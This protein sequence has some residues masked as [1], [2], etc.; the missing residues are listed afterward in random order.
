VD[1]EHTTL[2]PADRAALRLAAGTSP[3]A[4]ARTVNQLLEESTVVT[5]SEVFE[6]TPAEFQR[7]GT[8]V[9]LL[10]LA[11][12]FGNVDPAYREAVTFRPDSERELR[13]ILPH[14][15]FDASIRIEARE[16]A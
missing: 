7:L 13:V 9:T 12:G 10:D 16:T 8:L 2:P 3:R 1:L 14:L 11:I 5:G 4:V 6:H 15:I